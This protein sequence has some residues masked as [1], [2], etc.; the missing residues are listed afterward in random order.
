MS[1]KEELRERNMD[2]FL[3]VINYRT[4]L[5]KTMDKVLVALTSIVDYN[6]RTL[7]VTDPD[8]DGMLS[9]LTMRDTFKILGY[10]NY[11]IQPYTTK[12][13]LLSVDGYKRALYGGYDYVVIF[14]TASNEMDKLQDLVK[15]GVKVI[16][17]DHHMTENNY[18]DYPLGCTIINTRIENR[19]VGKELYSLSA[20]ALT[21]TVCDALLK[22]YGYNNNNLSA[23]AL[24]TL[25]SDSMDMTDKWNRS[26]YFEAIDKDILPFPIE[27]FMTEHTMFSRRFLVFR[28]I[29]KLNALFRAER[30]DLLNMIIADKRLTIDQL[31]LVEE[32][33]EE[34]RKVVKILSD[35]CTINY[36]ENIV[37][38]DISNIKLDMFERKY[39]LENFT[40]LLANILTEEYKKP[41][42]VIC[43]TKGSF[44]DYLSRNM[45]PV[46]QKFSD[47]NGH[48]S[49][50]GIRVDD[51][52]KFIEDC[53]KVDIFPESTLDYITLHV[54]DINREDLEDMAIYN[55][56]SSPSLKQA[57]IE[58]PT[59]YLEPTWDK[60]YKA[61]K[62]GNIKVKSNISLKHKDKVK[63]RPELSNTLYL[64]YHGE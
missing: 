59:D 29:N 23:Y 56:F 61:Y 15:A 6:L 1:F 40:G 7:L 46:F 9:L 8:P 37:M 53:K 26:I 63:L 17:L 57:V 47:S 25:Y 58:V 11:D 54:D 44:R 5:F 32:V 62:L 38:S 30:F 4:P 28:F 16:V 22:H 21:F 20:G 18:N 39:R 51:K 52:T 45:L 24:T 2:D 33:H 3:C 14:D 50:F 12:S 43:N 60:Y 64:Y 36:N 31:G 41:A 35:I 34:C 10:K 13:H 19:L 27:Q 48:P 49:A 55:E 42:V